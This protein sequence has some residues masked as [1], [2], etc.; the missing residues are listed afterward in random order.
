VDGIPDLCPPLVDQQIDQQGQ[1]KQR[2][3]PA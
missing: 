1:R 3:E 2:A